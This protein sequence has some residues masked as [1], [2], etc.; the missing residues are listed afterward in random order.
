MHKPEQNMQGKAPVSFL[1]GSAE[2]LMG[3]SDSTQK[4]DS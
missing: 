2:I 4:S 1:Q 3:L